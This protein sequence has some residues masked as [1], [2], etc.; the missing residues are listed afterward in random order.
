MQNDLF[1][2]GNRSP[3]PTVSVIQPYAELIFAG[4]KE[5][6]FHSRAIPLGRLAIY[7]PNFYLARIRIEFQHKPHFRD[8]VG[9]EIE[10]LDAG[11][12]VGLVDVVARERVPV[13]S[14]Q[15]SFW[16]VIPDEEIDR[17]DCIAPG[18]CCATLENPR[19]LKIPRAYSLRSELATSD[20]NIFESIW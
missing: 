10:D 3:V 7:A 12:I 13:R 1:E 2:R 19:R 17:T 9:C 18:M 14:E 6:L 15:S 4:H 5:R 8:L 16:D 20:P 11:V